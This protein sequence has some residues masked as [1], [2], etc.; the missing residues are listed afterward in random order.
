MAYV[1]DVRV[2]PEHAGRGAFRAFVTELAHR[3]AGRFAWVF[4][5]VLDENPHARA[6]RRVGAGF[7]TERVLGRFVHVGLPVVGR[8]PREN[9]KV[10]RIPASEAWSHYMRLADD[11]DMA[12]ADEARFLASPAEHLAVSRG[13][14]IIAA[15]QW[16]D[17]GR[18][19]RIVATRDR[20]VP[21]A[22]LSRWLVTRGGAPLARRGEVLPI[23][24]LSHF[25]TRTP[26][27]AVARA[28]AAFM[29]RAAPGRHSHVFF[30]VAPECAAAHQGLGTVRLTSTCFAYGATP[31]SLQLAFR[32]LS[33]I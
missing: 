21:E 15:A 28:L 13:G 10:S 5:S 1:H 9:L 33:W 18:E 27:P 4:C 20:T 24:Y 16:L 29:A 7:G 23:A 25:A 6:I 2:S 12:P 17:Q 30:G 19:R 22:L 3:H 11:R 14:Q 8:R 31:T 32:E 26:D